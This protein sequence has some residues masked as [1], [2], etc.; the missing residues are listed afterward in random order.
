MID[1]TKGFN[2]DAALESII[3][4]YWGFKKCSFIIYEGVKTMTGNSKAAVG[5]FKKNGLDC[6]K[7][8][9]ITHPEVHFS[10]NVTNN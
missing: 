4:D 2:I 3:Y 6:R 1:G 7:L 10:E 5:F 8:N 9:C